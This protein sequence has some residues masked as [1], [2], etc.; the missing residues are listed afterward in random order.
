MDINNFHR[1]M[2]KES[3]HPFFIRVILLTV[4]SWLFQGLLYMDK[5]ERIFKISLDIM[6]FTIF[7]IYISS[8]L[9]PVQSLLI[10]IIS[11]HTINWVF[12][13][14][15]FVLVKNLGFARNEYQ[16]FNKYLEKFY[17]RAK[18][19]DCILL[20]ATIGSIA[21]EELKETS[22]L[23]IRVIREQGFSSGIKTCVFIL[24]ERSRAFLARFPLDIYLLDTDVELSKLGENPVIIYK[25]EN[26]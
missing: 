7:Y 20:V 18:K 2:V 24:K 13:G 10:S 4:S 15:I 11:A 17:Q 23:D 21:R 26:S 1:K 6:I 3:K 9:N 19:E 16:D 12:N 8:Y 22:D 14:Q 5:T 25:K